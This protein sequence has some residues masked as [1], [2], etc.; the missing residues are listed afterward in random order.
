MLD[1][2]LDAG[3]AGYRIGYENPEHFSRDYKQRISID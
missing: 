2:T 3:D 1:E